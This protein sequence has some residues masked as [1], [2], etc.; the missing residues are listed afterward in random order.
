MKVCKNGLE[1]KAL[2]LQIIVE[3]FKG[4]T[5]FSP[6]QTDESIISMLQAAESKARGPETADPAAGARQAESDAETFE[7]QCKGKQA[8]ESWVRAEQLYRK[9][10]SDSLP[11]LCT[12]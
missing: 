4:V 10:G 11:L 12:K 7:A 6:L 5:L 1:E 3:L 8:Y 2:L 9:A